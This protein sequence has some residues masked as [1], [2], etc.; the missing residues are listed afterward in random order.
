MLI[1]P[2]FWLFLGMKKLLPILFALA[3]W[4]LLGSLTPSQGKEDSLSTKINLALRRTADGLLRASG[5][6][7]S[8]IPAVERVGEDVWRVMLE[9]PF[10]YAKLPALLQGSLDRYGISR[11]YEVAVRRCADATIDLGYHQLDALQDGFV[12]CAGR[13]M[14]EGCHYIEVTFAGDAGTGIPI[15][16]RIGL[17]LLALVGTA[18]LWWVLQRKKPVVPEEGNIQWI[19]FGNSRLDLAG[20]TL[21][22]GEHRQS[23]TYREAKLLGLFAA[24][25]DQVIERDQILRDVWADEGVLV[26]RSVDVF[27]S[28][29]RKKLAADASVAI[30]AVHGVGY[31]L[32]TGKEITELK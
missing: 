16:G 5:D 18:G 15:G 27:V 22:C 19:T 28:R 4:G 31:R 20:Q 17:S 26:G 7:T 8:R 6:S 29:L 10:D 23:L 13:E 21:L 9:Q 25:P 30:V 14:A 32:E 3:I 24:N 11:S 1:K 2:E 12:P